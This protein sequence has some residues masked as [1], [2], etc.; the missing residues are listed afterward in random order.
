M[1]H[2][3]L[4]AQQHVGL[5]VSKWG[6]LGRF[7]RSHLWAFHIELSACRKGKETSSIVVTM[8][9]PSSSQTMVMLS[10]VPDGFGDSTNSSP[11]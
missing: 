8:E 7:I 3:C 9:M 5:T 2:T 11:Y 1:Q 10:T 4:R 6:R